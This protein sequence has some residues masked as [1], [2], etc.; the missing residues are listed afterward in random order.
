MLERVNGVRFEKNA[1]HALHE[2]YEAYQ[3]ALFE[4]TNL[5]CIHHKRQ[6]ISPKDMQ[7]ARHIRG[8]RSLKSCIGRCHFW[9][10]V[11]SGSSP[12]FLIT[13]VTVSSPNQYA[14]LYSGPS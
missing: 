2:A 10:W 7:L 4:D 3:V 5:Q 14:A 1:V 11:T 9:D 13:T 8:E 6:T 12:H